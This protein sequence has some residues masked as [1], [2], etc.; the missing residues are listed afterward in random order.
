MTQTSRMLQW[1]DKAVEPAGDSKSDAWY[2]NWF[3]KRLKELYADS[4]DPKDRPIL[5][6]T[7]DYEHDESARTRKGRTVGAKSA[8]GNQRLLYGPPASKLPA[9]PT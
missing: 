3:A 6:M 5:D 8:A 1:H 4:T 7:W 9:S 2:F